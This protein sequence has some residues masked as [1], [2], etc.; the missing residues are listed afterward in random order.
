MNHETTKEYA[1]E[2]REKVFKVI[3]D[4]PDDTR[5]LPGV[6]MECLEPL[7]IEIAKLRT[8]IG[9]NHG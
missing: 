2:L 4:S 3:K 5:T 8:E 1:N 7:I 6:L 9:E